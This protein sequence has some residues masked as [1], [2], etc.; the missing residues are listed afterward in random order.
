MKHL[1]AWR[2]GDRIPYSANLHDF[3]VELRL[4]DGAVETSWGARVDIEEALKAIQAYQ[5]GTLARGVEI[6]PYT[7]DHTLPDGGVKIGC[8]VI[9]KGAIEALVLQLN[10][11]LKQYAK[12]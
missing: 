11:G 12:N 1:E 6:G 7:F 8:H 3:P 2:R 5:A 10:K 4:I 9:S